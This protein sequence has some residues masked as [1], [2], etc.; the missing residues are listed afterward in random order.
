MHKEQIQ[1]TNPSTQAWNGTSYDRL[2]TGLGWFSIALGA[3]QVAASGAVAKIAG[4][5][6]DSGNRRLLRSP[7]YG[8]REL[9]AGA[10]ILTRTQPAP[11]LWSRVAGDVVDL[12]T[13][14]AALRSCRNDRTRVALAMGAVAGVTALDILCARHLSRRS[15]SYSEPGREPA[16]GGTTLGD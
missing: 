8:M 13:L 6:N 11:W 3:A 4:I 12:G 7:L 5:A 10:G 14:A 2:A 1:E 16:F 15:A 9:A